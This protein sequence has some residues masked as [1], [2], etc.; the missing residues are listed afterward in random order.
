MTA[1]HGSRARLFGSGLEISAYLREMS[2]PA[3]RDAL[4]RTTFG[5]DHKRFKAG[6][7]NATLSGSG[8]FDGDPE[9]VDEAM[10]AALGDPDA[11]LTYL[12]AGDGFGKA[13][14]GLIGS[15]TEYEVGTPVAELATVGFAV[16][17]SAGR[18]SLRI[19][20]ALSTTVATG[21]GTGYDGGAASTRGG[22][23]YLQVT[24]LAGDTTLD[25]KVQHS[26]DDIVYVDL[27]TFAQAA[28]RGAQRIEVDGTVEQYVRE[29]RVVA[30]A[31]PEATYH[32]AFG[33]R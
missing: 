3:D 8:L 11:P 17:S 14:V 10:D 26:D 12:P 22:V 18:E 13:A 31:A 2:L 9:Q 25:V 16:Q 1:I 19:L 28:V 24:D 32:I 4:D 20:R 15:Y 6:L 21:N 30:G 29:S 33:R 5:N 23:G 27:I 7:R